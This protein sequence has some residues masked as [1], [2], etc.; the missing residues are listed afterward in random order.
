MIKSSCDVT[1]FFVTQGQH[2]VLLRLSGKFFERT[3]R[4]LGH[5]DVSEDL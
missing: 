4:A 2:S 5:R 1:L 3:Y